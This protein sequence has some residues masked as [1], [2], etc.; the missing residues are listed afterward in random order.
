[1]LA[2]KKISLLK[3]VIRSQSTFHLI[4]FV[5][6]FQLVFFRMCALKLSITSAAKLRQA[7]AAMSASGPKKKRKKFPVNADIDLAF[8]QQKVNPRAGSELCVASLRGAYLIIISFVIIEE[9]C[10]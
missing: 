7:E 3:G 1:M 4:S 2:T 8:S 10:Y 9:F 6:I 5:L